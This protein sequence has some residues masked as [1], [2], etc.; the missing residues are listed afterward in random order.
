MGNRPKRAESVL[1]DGIKVR[2]LREKA[3]LT[4]DQLA[5]E[6]TRLGWHL[7][8]GYLPSLE[9]KPSARVHKQLAG[10]LATALGIPV[11]ELIVGV[12]R[13]SRGEAT[14]TTAGV[15]VDRPQPT[16]QCG[17]GFDAPDISKRHAAGRIEV[18]REILREIAEMNRRTEEIRR[19]V[20]EI[21]SR[22][23]QER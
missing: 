10:A 5:A 11:T 18:L 17:F 9:K 15:V 12:P 3:G 1:I 13:G 7:S 23:E 16:L 6:V 14:E 2:D 21:L 19:V 8:Q 20:E 22:E 4:Q